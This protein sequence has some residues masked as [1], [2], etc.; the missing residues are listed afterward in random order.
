MSK[1]DFLMSGIIIL[2]VLLG[3]C[4]S[5][6]Q[7]SEVF[8]SGI[9][10]T[11]LS[12]YTT[13]HEDFSELPQL[14]EQSRLS[15]YLRY[16]AVNNPGLEAAFHRCRGAA[17]DVWQVKSLP[18]PRITYRYFIEQVETRVGAQKQAFGISQMLP[19]FG[20]L[21]LRGDAAAQGANSARQRYEAANYW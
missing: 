21:G 10:D 11:H 16:A 15:D 14:H 7:E 9:G 17:E 5:S 12:D 8:L 3:G 6:R 4:G 1:V 19:W 18:D 2:G 13:N 20:K